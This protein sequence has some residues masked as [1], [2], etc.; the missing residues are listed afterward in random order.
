MVLQLL[1]S[2]TCVSIYTHIGYIWEETTT[3]GWEISCDLEGGAWAMAVQG[4]Q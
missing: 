4:A 3:L 1:T 2:G